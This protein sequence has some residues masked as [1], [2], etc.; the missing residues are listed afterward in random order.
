MPY[1]DSHAERDLQ[2]LGERV[3]TGWAKRYPVTAKELTAVHEALRQQ[4]ELEHGP[5]KP[6]GQDQSPTEATR[7]QEAQRQAAEQH[8]NPPPQ[9]S[10]DQDRGHSH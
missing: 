6:A 4:W 10:Q 1:E 7:A 8:Q 5:I 9:N 2:E 3:R